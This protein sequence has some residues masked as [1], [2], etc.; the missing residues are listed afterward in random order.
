MQSW[1]A[2]F[3]SSSIGKKVLMALSGLALIGFLFV[4]VAGNLSLFAD[5]EGTAFNAYAGKLEATQP[6]LFVAEIALLALFVVHVSLALVVTRGNQEARRKGYA[7][8]SSLGRRTLAS[9]S[10]VVTGLLVLVF[11]VIHVVDFRLPRVMGREGYDDLAAVVKARLA[12]PAGAAIYLAGVAALGVHLRHAFHSALQTLGLQH[13][14]YTPWLQRV[15]VAIAVLLFLGFASF[16]VVLF[17]GG[18]R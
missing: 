4:H 14:R 16:P 9:S 17:L 15:G 10:M 6:L 7:V 2:R 1:L 11:L 5:G 8:R 12:S 13:P 3:V 18:V